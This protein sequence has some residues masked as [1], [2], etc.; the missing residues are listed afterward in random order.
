MDQPAS[1]SRGLWALWHRTPLYQRIVA[2][3]LLGLVV[4]LVLGPRAASFAVPSKLVLRLLGA[5][6]PALIL[7]A[8]IKALLEARFEPGTAGRLIRLLVLN[9]LVAIGV[10]LLVANVLRPGSWSAQLHAPAAGAG[11][12]GAAGPDL[13]QQFL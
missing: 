7:V 13:L 12:H 4:G 6:A 11:K 9:T 2:G 3:M 8:I 10:G 1:E 5:L